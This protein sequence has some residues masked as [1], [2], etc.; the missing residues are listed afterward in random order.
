VT[1]GDVVS[2]A[3]ALLWGFAR[4][5]AKE[6]PELGATAIDL[7]AEPGPHEAEALFRE[8]RD[9]TDE[10]Q[11]AIRENERFV[12][13][14]S[15]V[16]LAAARSGTI[17]RFRAEVGIPGE[18]ASVSWREAPRRRPAP[19]EVEIEVLAVGLNFRDVLL[20]LGLLPAEPDGEIPLGFECSGRIAAVGDRV[21][22]L[23][24]GDEVFGL[25][26]SSLSS[27]ARTH[28]A[29]VTRKPAGLDF[30]T[31]AAMPWSRPR[32]TLDSPG[33]APAPGACSPR[34]R[35]G[36]ACVRVAQAGAEVYATAG[37]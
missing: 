21:E 20:A 11:V 18:L 3:G 23:A 12:A 16:H 9:S 35:R 17:A 25:A 13:R 37:P 14:L 33:E 1:A 34:R 5:L 2:P 27:F 22:G 7:G 29:L 36:L 24:V 31:A 19:D 4:T 30:E 6:H 32:T 26:R 28:G 15:R 10:T 8:L